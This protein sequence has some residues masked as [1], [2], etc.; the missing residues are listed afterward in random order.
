MTEKQKEKNRIR[1]KNYRLNNR[2]KAYAKVKEC[3]AKNKESY[4]L[5]AKKYKEINKDKI[6]IDNKKYGIKNREKIN[7]RLSNKYHTDI[8]AK[9][10][11]NLRNRLNLLMK[12]KK[13]T[14]SLIKNIGCSVEELKIHLEKQFK[15]GM[16]WE[17][18]GR[19]GWHI[20][21]IIPLCSFDLTDE[22]QFLK[23]V[24]YTNLQ[25]LW[26]KDNLEKGRKLPAPKLKF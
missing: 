25:P 4:L 5:K 20:D 1:S 21:H 7:K 12:N 2:E 13:K 10:K 18:K 3:Y 23:A 11:V 19:M 22:K 26:A 9:L 6:K 16:T 14:L 24:H 17:N 8:Q 15:P